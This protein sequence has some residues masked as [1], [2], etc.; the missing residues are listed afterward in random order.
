M[1]TESTRDGDAS[2]KNGRSRMSRGLGEIWNCKD[3]FDVIIVGSGYGGSAAA[4]LLAGHQVQDPV[5]KQT[6]PARV[7]VLERGN[8]Y[9]P[10]EFPS[11]FDRLPGHLRRTHQTT[12]Q[13]SGAEG[14][15]DVRLG[16]DVIAM[17]ANGLGGGSL[18]NA[19]VM[20]APNVADFVPGSAGSTLVTSLHAGGWPGTGSWFE[21]AQRLLGGHVQD[22]RGRWVPNDIARHARHGSALPVKTNALAALAG[23]NAFSAPPLTVS[24]DGGPNI[25]NVKLSACTL[26]GDCMTGCNVGAKNSLDANLLHLAN[27]RKVDIIT[28]ASVLSLRRSRHEDNVPGN[29]HWVLRV[30]HTSQ[31][32][33]AKEVNP[34]RL[35]ARKVILAAGT[36]GTTE[37]LLRSR[38]ERVVFSSTLGERF[39]CNGDNLAAAYRLPGAT[40]SVAD[41]TV[42]LD[43]RDIGPTITGTIAVPATGKHRAFQIQEFSVPGPMNMLFGETVT[44]S[45][46]LNTLP[47]ADNDVHGDEPTDRIDPFAVDPAAIEHTLVLG[48]I[49]HDASNGSLSLARAVR[50]RNGSTPQ[51]GGLRIKF[52]DAKRAPQMDEAHA[53]LAGLIETNGGAQARLLPNPVWRLLPKDLE[54]LVSQPRGPVLTVHPLGGCAMGDK[55]GNG[56]GAAE[57]VVDTWG[58]VYDARRY[59]PH[60]AS[61]WFGTLVALDGSILPSSLGV[62]PAL[63]ITATAL[64]AI[65]QLKQDWGWQPDPARNPA[66]DPM[67]LVLSGPLAHQPVSRRRLPMPEVPSAPARR[68]TQ[69]EIVERLR[70][71]MVLTR[72]HG[73]QRCVVELTLAYEPKPLRALI[74]TLHRKLDVASTEKSRLRIYD[75]DEWD[76]HLLQTERDE[77]RA[78][79]ALVE[80]GIGGTL[81]LFRREASGPWKRRL[82]SAWAWLL[83]RGLRDIG[84]RFRPVLNDTPRESIGS[85]IG[86]LL[87][88]STRAGEVRLMTYDLEIG[89]LLRVRD[90]ANLFSLLAEG[91]SIVGSKRITYGRRANPWNQLT[92]LPLDHFPGMVKGDRPA[93]LKLDGR[94]LANQGF[95]LLRVLQQ[96]NEALTLADLASFGMY[97]ARMLVSIHLWTFRKPDAASEREPVRLPEPIAGLADPDITEITVGRMPDSD[98]PVMVRLTRYRDLCLVDH[99]ELDTKPPLVMIHG[100]SVSGNTFT[101]ASL[102]PSAAEF[103]YR[104]GRDVWVVDL[105]TST[106]MPTALY[107]WSMEMVGLVDIPAALLHIKQVTG[108]RVDVLAH[109]IGCVMLSMA[110]LSDA[111]E[112]RHDMQQLGVDTFLT[113]EQLGTLA[114]FNGPDPQGGDHPCIRRIV[115]SQKGPILRYTDGN[116][117]RAFVMQSVRR[118]LMTDH[119]RFQPSRRPG[120]LEGLTDRLLASIPYPD[121]DYDVENPL[122]FTATTPWTASRH[123]MDALYGRDFDAGNLRP[124][125]LDAIDDLF[126]PMNLDTVAQTI[127][128]ARFGCITN[129]AGRGEFV[130]TRRLRERWGGIPT[131][132]LHGHNNGLVDAVT[133]ELLRQ[134][135]EEAGVPFDGPDTT[136]SPYNGL[137][138][139]DVLIGRQSTMV[140]E[141]IERFLLGAAP[142]R[143]V[144]VKFPF[145]AM[146]PWSGPRFDLPQ[147]HEVASIGPT[148][149]IACLSAPHQGC[150]HLL[151]LP[152]IRLGAGAQA[153]FET[154]PPSTA[155]AASC[156]PMGTSDDW[157]FAT[158]VWSSGEADVDGELGWF[159]V[160]VYPRDETVARHHPDFLP[161]G[162]AHQAS[163]LA[164][165]SAQ[166]GPVVAGTA[167]STPAAAE[168]AANRAGT[169]FGPDVTQFT[170]HVTDLHLPPE[171]LRARADAPPLVAVMG[172]AVQP[173]PEPLPLCDP[174]AHAEAVQWIARQDNDQRRQVFVT[175]EEWR[176]A[177]SL[178]APDHEAPLQ[179]AVMSCQY[180]AGLLD[181]YC[182][183]ASLR[184]LGERQDHEETRVD[185]ALMIGDQIYADATAGLVDPVRRDELFDQPN[186]RAL[187]L[188]AMREVLRRM[189]AFMLC[190]DHEIH[191]DWEP[192]ALRAAKQRP[193]DDKRNEAWLRNGM[194]AFWKFQRMRGAPKSPR[195]SGD[196]AFDLRGIP[197]RFVDTRTGREA[198]GTTRAAFN[199][200]ILTTVQQGELATWLAQHREQLKFIATPSLLLPRRRFTVEDHSAGAAFSDAWDGYPQSLEW[201]L[202]HLV[203]HGITRTVFLSGDEHHALFSTIRV[204]RRGQSQAAVQIVSVHSSALYAPFPF[205]NGQPENLST[206]KDFDLGPLRVEVRT[207]HAAPGDGY[208][209]IRVD[210]NRT[211]IS[212]SFAKNDPAAAPPQWTPLSV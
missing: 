6:R 191:D 175:L 16:D 197:F 176:N 114:A 89:P 207:T 80:A 63:T 17:V 160:V 113:S 23:T 122:C 49:G 9:L 55:P 64:R 2:G 105:R 153:R 43:Q 128:F 209:R 51:Q 115:L 142:E 159:A 67:S 186:D 146:A 93:V 154:A 57:G 192:M 199:P 183:E 85:Y 118:W 82:R 120:V 18:I 52:P 138:H 1:T 130:T 117:F 95:P 7:C 173:Q 90:N 68:E 170:G 91:S 74:S 126:G 149:R 200:S 26:C 102:Q 61:P 76:R 41:E 150:G 84:D 59:G 62:N 69:I 133:Q 13:V 24:M 203:D 166:T 112:V 181:R 28:G 29:E 25:A 134:H 5:T 98:E 22:G 45:D 19:G 163:A 11:T 44:T 158:P 66:E 30:A 211:A 129:Q 100:Y 36:L 164:P 141:D 33:Q 53:T 65:E 196:L 187:R 14:L 157:L 73:P 32:L 50:P 178:L 116:I 15:L 72:D 79:F 54:G 132:A 188:P 106:G 81:T 155:L 3:V 96:Q 104:R 208:V 92:Q 179:F 110:V 152:G 168:P 27:E 37:I 171:L 206:E 48:V 107:P 136:A 174:D 108:K 184:A 137:G 161:R 127:H 139:Q 47:T 86:S 182:A 103:F 180:T 75:Q 83:N 60:E 190:D 77:V 135:F 124:A 88:L 204:W 202:T 167:R 194:R 71:P 109:C 125:T 20:L 39:S 201:L 121:A 78:P 34:C 143:R 212:V 35:R 119:F 40:S 31:T 131:F 177:Q 210:Q 195:G 198:R 87:R 101:H 42:A 205:A 111:R 56:T 185:A 46:T 148:V 99:P 156:S 169:F 12:G 151:L 145:V 97:I 10:G 140:F 21:S 189:P 144:V 172:P 162:A 123:R 8:E 165:P 58:R 94:F 147:P 193:D 38:D 70:G 4:A